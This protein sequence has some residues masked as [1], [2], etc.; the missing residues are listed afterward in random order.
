MAIGDA[1]MGAAVLAVWWIAASSVSGVPNLAANLVLHG[2]GIALL[3]V[4]ARGQDSWLG[5][6]PGGRA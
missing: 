4:L 6:H 2:V 1:I 3:L 5:A